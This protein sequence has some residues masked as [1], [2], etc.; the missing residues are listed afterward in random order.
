[1]K[2]LGAKAR[3]VRYKIDLD[4]VILYADTQFESGRN[5]VL[6]VI[7]RNEDG[8]KI[9]IGEQSKGRILDFL[10]QNFADHDVWDQI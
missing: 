2:I 5:M 8:E 1:M 9:N 3:E 10:S 6:D 4:G 7:I